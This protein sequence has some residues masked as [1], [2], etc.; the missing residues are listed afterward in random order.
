MF[1]TKKMYSSQKSHKKFKVNLTFNL[2]ES[3]RLEGNIKFFLKFSK[4][5]I[6]FLLLKQ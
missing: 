1:K 4:L 5:S 3:H 2:T 6:V